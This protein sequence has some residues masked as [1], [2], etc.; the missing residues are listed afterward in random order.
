MQEMVIAYVWQ[1]WGGKELRVKKYLDL[2]E[3]ISDRLLAQ[4]VKGLVQSPVWARKERNI[5]EVGNR[6]LWRLMDM[7]GGKE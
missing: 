3:Q 6:G 4:H 2:V 7:R 1:K 5:Q